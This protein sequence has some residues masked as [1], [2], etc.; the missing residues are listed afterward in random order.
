MTERRTVEERGWIV[1]NAGMERTGLGRVWIDFQKR[2]PETGKVRR[3]RAFITEFEGLFDEWRELIPS[4]EEPT[5]D[6]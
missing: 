4:A 2:D 3:R 6:A 1:V 5:A